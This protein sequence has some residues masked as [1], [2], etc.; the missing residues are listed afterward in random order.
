MISG[1][2]LNADQEVSDRFKKIFSAQVLKDSVMASS[3]RKGVETSGLKDKFLVIAGSGHLDF[4]FG[5]PERLDRLNLVPK[6]QTCIVTVMDGAEVEFKENQE[7]GKVHKF[8][9]AYA[10]DYVFIYDDSLEEH[11]DGEEVKSEIVFVIVSPKDSVA[12][13]TQEYIGYESRL[14]Q[15]L[16]FSYHFQ[17][18]VKSEISAAYDR[19][20]STAQI[21]GTCLSTCSL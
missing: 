6:N 16:V 3:I 5:V 13:L 21:S 7:F 11:E 9:N 19:I 10:G 8:E 2:D 12:K 1:R 17:S 14:N 15:P 20:A 18:S 4:R